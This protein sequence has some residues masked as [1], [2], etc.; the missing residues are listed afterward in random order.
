[1]RNAR[2][3]PA[4]RGSRFAALA[5]IVAFTVTVACRHVAGPSLP[6]QPLPDRAAIDAQVRV[7]MAAQDVKGLALAVIDKGQIVHVGAYGHRN[8][9]RNLALEPD[10]IMYGAS[11]TKAAFAYMV[12][13]LVDEG[14]FDLDRPLAEYLPKPLYAYETYEPLAQDERWRLL[15]ARIVLNHGTGLANFYWLEEDSKIRFHWT[16]GE[17]YGYSGQG[18]YILQLALEEGLGLDIHEQMQSRVFDRFG[19]TRTS[20][21]WRP[22]FAENLADGYT[23]DNSFEPHD[24]RSNARA[25]GSMDTTIADSARLWAGVVRGDGLSK[26]ARAELVRAGLAIRSA[27]QFPP[28]DPKTDRRSEAMGLAAGLGVI[29]FN[30]TRGRTWFKGGHN[31]STGNML[32]CQEVGHR[33]LV[34]LANSVRAEKIYPQLANAILGD[35][36]MPWWWEYGDAP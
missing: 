36:G 18:F 3:K 33:C 22:D 8:V 17:R 15:T 9:E 5:A 11:L 32:I 21:R 16:P 20:M 1:M 6:A 14:R 29:T 4:H 26:S 27:H 24:E 35:S 19:M 23:L 34:M 30:G 7:L 12:L 28:L 25:A 2:P 10:T 31:D 13:Q